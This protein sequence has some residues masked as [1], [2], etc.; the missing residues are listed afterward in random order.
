MP[1]KK[2]EKKEEKFEEIL[3]EIDEEKLPLA[4]ALIP[5]IIFLRDLLEKIK[6]TILDNGV[7]DAYPNG[8]I[9]ESPAVKSFNATVKSYGILCK[10]LETMMKKDSKIKQE[11]NSLQHWLESMK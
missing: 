10:Q 11:K 9:K 8:A 7:V 3:K 1:K 4:R 6:K 5:Q 2:D